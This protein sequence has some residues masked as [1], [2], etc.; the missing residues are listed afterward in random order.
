LKLTAALMRK[1]STQTKKTA[2]SKPSLANP[3]GH[4]FECVAISGHG[5][6]LIE[7][8]LAACGWDGERIRMQ[9]T[10]GYDLSRCATAYAIAVLASE[11]WSEC[12]A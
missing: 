1:S 8:A 12:P 9:D 7:S 4:M 3:G 6:F 5:D 2:V 10:L 11:E